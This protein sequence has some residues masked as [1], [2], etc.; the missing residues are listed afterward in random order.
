MPSTRWLSARATTRTKPSSPL[1]VRARP[2]AANGNRP[3]MHLVPGLARLLGREADGD[4]LRIGEAD[5]RDRHAA[6]RRRRWPAMISAT[7]SP[8]AM[9][10]W[11]SI[12]S[13]VRSPTAQ[14]LRIEV[15]QR[16]SIRTNGAV[17]RRGR[18]VRAR[19]PSCRRAGRPRRGA[20][21]PGCARS[22]PSGCA[23]RSAS[24]SSDR[25]RASAPVSTST[26]SA[27]RRAGTGRVS[28]AS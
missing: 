20:C 18:A 16:S 2:L 13:P 17:H 24:P 28:S 12:G 14:T 11:A 4:D 22:A 25:P 6:R 23:I 3:T 8:C 21:R 19:S 27:F 7:I 5:G 15:A 26:P 10:R 9:A 1:S